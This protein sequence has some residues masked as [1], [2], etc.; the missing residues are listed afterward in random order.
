MLVRVFEADTM[1][2]ALKKV[3]EALGPDALILSTRTVRKNGL[4]MFR[5]PICEITAAI[6]DPAEAGR[7]A[8]TPQPESPGGPQAA[9]PPVNLATR[10]DA[11]APED[12][13]TYQDLWRQRRVIDPL[14]EEVR[15]LK[16]QVNGNGL[17]AVR[18]EI[19]ELKAMLSQLAR[20][21]VPA[22][23]ASPAAPVDIPRPA[24]RS[25]AEVQEM[26][27]LQGTL[28]RLGI[29]GEAAAQLEQFAWE[30]LSPRQLADPQRIEEFLAGAVA[31]LI[32]VTGPLQ[33]RP[34]RQRC[35]ALV[36]PTGVGKTT[37]IA[38]IAAGQRMA[39][40]QRI[41]LLTIDTYRIAAVEQLKVY[42]EIMGLPVEVILNPEQLQQA[43]LRHAD[44]DLI[45]IDTAGRSPRDEASLA[46]LELFLGPERGTENCL[47]LSATTR[48]LELRETVRRFGRL[49][50]HSLI[51][52]KLDECE[53]CGTL[54]N[55]AVQQRL[56]LSFLTNGQRVPEDLLVA[57]P[58]AI[59]HI[60][61]GAQ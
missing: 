51:F 41:A 9:V 3:K 28:A 15:E 49:P 20:T 42:G 35:I 60:I 59:A 40:L 46:E 5:K 57:E 13:L 8:G 34:G 11:E 7:A 14:E 36:G 27:L 22:E 39:G 16:Q 55:I 17:A 48:D 61:T 37:T 43:L 52:T 54:L 29:S 23:T 38:K 6:D 4:G 45:L 58:G 10:A 18:S 24:S 56:P 53:Q 12:T 50:L 33:S 26:A 2:A 47:V 25:G 32:R 44:K 31:Q 1:T 30:Q 19:D 21:H